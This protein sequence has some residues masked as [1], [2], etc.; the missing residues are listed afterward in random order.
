M[1]QNA[2]FFPDFALD[3]FSGNDPDQDVKSFL[4]TVE[5]KIDCPLELPPN[6]ADDA[7]RYLFTKKALFS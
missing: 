7:A 1:A 6:A 3:K 4:L 2:V 5:N